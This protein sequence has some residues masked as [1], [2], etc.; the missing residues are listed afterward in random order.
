VEALVRIR[1]F[2]LPALVVVLLAAS[3][4]AARAGSFILILDDVNDGL[5]AT[6]I[7]DDSFADQDNFAGGAHR[8][9]SI[10]SLSTQVGSFT[11]DIFG[12]TFGLTP[13]PAGQPS[14]TGAPVQ[15]NL[16][17]FLVTSS[18]V[19]K[20]TATLI[21]TGVPGSIFDGPSVFGIAQYG[22]SFLDGAGRVGFKSS[23]NG[24]TVLDDSTEVDLPL[25]G[26]PSPTA[27]VG[28]IP[29]DPAGEFTLISELDFEIFSVGLET[30]EASINGNT[31]LSVENVRVPEPTTLLL[32]GPGMLGFAALRRRRL[33][34]K[35]L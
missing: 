23:V 2:L 30:G 34:S 20:F 11:V 35:A 16:T 1:N 13:P 14:P 6:T 19:G 33:R 25:F 7:T 28:P 31:A 21:R 27:T 26:Q 24:V 3:A 17:N 9:D 22:A 18:T 8:P 10:I 12:T 4:T 5:A 29:I 32:F 15:M